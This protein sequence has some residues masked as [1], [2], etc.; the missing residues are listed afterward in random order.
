MKVSRR[1]LK[2]VARGGTIPPGWRMAWYEP[3]RRT[4]VYGPMPLHWILRFIREF[5]YR[6][7]WVFAA[8]TIEKSEFLEMQR[9]LQERQ[10]LAD[11]Y[12]RGYLAGWQE[13]FDAC[14]SA[15]EDECGR[16][17]EVWQIGALLGGSSADQQN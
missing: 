14:L 3:R 8:P 17:K 4:A 5:A 7:R 6:L 12:S 1:V 16:A 2:S 11:E 15:I 13:C 10:R 9:S